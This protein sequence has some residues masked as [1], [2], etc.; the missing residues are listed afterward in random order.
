[1]R[2]S[3]KSLQDDLFKEFEK[4]FITYNPGS[5]SNEVRDIVVANIVTFLVDYVLQSCVEDI[6]NV[7]KAGMPRL[8]FD[9]VFSKNIESIANTLPLVA[10]DRV[11]FY[12]ELAKGDYKKAN[13]H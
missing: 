13:K 1:M 11:N 6:E 2:E 12:T 7:A 5:V 9:E 8:P 3:S 10:R 4:I